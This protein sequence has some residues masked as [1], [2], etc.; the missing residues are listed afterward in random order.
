[1]LVKLMAKLDSYILTQFLS[2]VPA[3]VTTAFKCSELGSLVLDEHRVVCLTEAPWLFFI[4]FFCFSF[5]AGEVCIP[6]P[7]VC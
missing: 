3:V 5:L 2:F 6:Q 4:F 1:M 7:V